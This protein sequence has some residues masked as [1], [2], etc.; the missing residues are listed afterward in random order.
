MVSRGGLPSSTTNST[1]SKHP[2]CFARR[3]E[4]TFHTFARQSKDE[5]LGEAEEDA[6]I[7]LLDEDKNPS[8]LDI[9]GRK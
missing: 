4:R 6:N 5:T 7:C 2:L 1:G 8:D 3:G 9:P